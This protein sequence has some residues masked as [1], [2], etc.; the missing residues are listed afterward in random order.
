M[1]LHIHSDASYLS[2]SHDHSRFGGLFYLADKPPNDDTINGSILKSAAVIKNVIV[3]AAY[4]EVGACFQNAESG[5]PLRVTLTE[6]GHKQ[7]ATALRTDDS[8]AF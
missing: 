1:I 7:P 2:V 8:T 3:S 4:A 5:A 6:F